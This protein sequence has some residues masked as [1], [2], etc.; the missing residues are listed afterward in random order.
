MFCQ[1]YNFCHCYHFFSHSSRS[2]LASPFPQPRVPLQI[3]KKRQVP[4]KLAQK[5][6]E[7]A[8]YSRLGPVETRFRAFTLGAPYGAHLPRNRRS[9]RLREGRRCTGYDCASVRVRSVCLLYGG[10]LWRRIVSF[11][12]SLSLS[13]SGGREGKRERVSGAHVRVR[14]ARGRARGLRKGERTRCTACNEEGEASDVKWREKG[15]KNVCESR[16]SWKWGATIDP[17]ALVRRNGKWP[18][19]NSTPPSGFGFRL[20]DP[21]AFRRFPGNLVARAFRAIARCVACLG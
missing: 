19:G 12:L 10:G 6:S 2:R 7:P 13:F 5:S 15:K 14:A 9:K 16:W 8:R 17:A 1:T 18:F 3:L 20:L 4:S 11:S 21:P